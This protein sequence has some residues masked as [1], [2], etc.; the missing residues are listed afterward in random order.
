MSCLLGVPTCFQCF[1]RSG[2]K[3]VEQV[4]FFSVFSHRIWKLWVHKAFLLLFF[5]CFYPLKWVT[6]WQGTLY[7]TSRGWTA[8]L[9]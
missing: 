1:I 2:G 6:A 4:P 5:L 3:H 7:H 8:L 9:I